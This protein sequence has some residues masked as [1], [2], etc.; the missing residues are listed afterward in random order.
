MNNY[1]RFMN[2]F[3]Q[4]NSQLARLQ[5]V[6]KKGLIAKDLFRV[7]TRPDMIQL[8]YIQVYANK[9][10]IT[11]GIEEDTTLDGIS[12]DDIHEL[13]ASLKDGTYRPNPVKRVPIPKKSG[14]ERNLGIP[15]SDD[16]LVQMAMKICLEHIYEQHFSECSHGFRPQRSCH[17]ALRQIKHTFTS[18][19]WFVEFDIKGFFDNVNHETLIALLETRIDDKR[20]IKLLRRFLKAGYM[21]NWDWYPSYSGMPQG[22]V[23]SPLLSNIYLHELDKF[24]E[25]LTNDFDKGKC[26]PRNPKYNGLTW[27]MGKIKKHIDEEGN[28]PE[29]LNEFKRLEKERL[30]IPHHIENNDR[31]KRLV[32]CRYA[33]DFIFGVIGS[34]TDAKNLLQKTESFLRDNLQL[35]LSPEKTCVQQS[36]KGIEFLSYGIKTQYADKIKKIKMDGRYARR[37]TISGIILLTVPDDK[38]REFCQSHEYGDWQKQKSLHRPKLLNATEAEIIYAYN[39]EIRGFANYYGLARDMKHSLNFLSFMERSSLFK[40]LANKRKTSIMK[41][42]KDLRTPDGFAITVQT[43]DKESGEYTDKQVDVWQLKHW[44]PTPVCNDRLPLTTHLYLSGSELYLR[45]NAFEC[46]YCGKRDRPLEVHHIHKLKDLKDMTHLEHW[47]KVMIARHRKTMILCGGSS[48]SCHVLL[49]QGKLSDKR[50]NKEWQGFP[51]FEPEYSDKYLDYLDS[52]AGG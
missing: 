14:G 41:V 32:Y 27:Q 35:D 12:H 48:D 10:A 39:A 1:E 46:E 26:R 19:K 43:R 51:R 20:F 25:S 2:E 24:V 40:T 37:R 44:K 47:Q 16:K 50:F 21:E 30:Q 52:V 23:I 22:G 9:G 6:S 36:D 13:V 17:T 34:Y 49:H 18:V 11:K 31:F 4:L 29:R 3:P 5:A 8:A 38:V 45:M 42:I 7:I 28:T 15:T 33:D